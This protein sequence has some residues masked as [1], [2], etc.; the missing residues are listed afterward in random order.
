MTLYH[1]IYIQVEFFNLKLNFWVFNSLILTIKALSLINNKMKIVRISSWIELQSSIILIAR[2]KRLKI[3]QLIPRFICYVIQ[4]QDDI[5]ARWSRSKVI[6][7][8][9]DPGARRSR[10][11]MTQVQGDPNAGWSRCK[12]IQVQGDPG[13]HLILSYDYDH[14]RSVQS[15]YPLFNEHM[16]QLEIMVIFNNPFY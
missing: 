12:A 1:P 10:V 15:A 14:K 2:W 5:G 3:N 16:D 9:A 4:V 11:K 6:Q 13:A 7:L 8:Q